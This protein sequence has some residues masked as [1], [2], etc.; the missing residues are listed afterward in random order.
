MRLTIVLITC[1][2]CHTALSQNNPGTFLSLY[3]EGSA[4]LKEKNLVK[5]EEVFL[6]AKDAGIREHGENSAD[7][8]NTYWS[9]TYVY[10]D[11]D[12]PDKAGETYYKVLKIH[13]SLN[14]VAKDKQD[15]IAFTEELGNFLAEKNKS[16]A[17]V[18]LFQ[19]AIR[20][21]EKIQFFEGTGYYWDL[22]NIM[23]YSYNQKKYDSL[24]Y[25]FG[26]I[27]PLL[28]SKS[29]EVRYAKHLSDW[30]S[31]LRAQKMYD[32]FD[33]VEKR[34]E[35]YLKARENEKKD[36]PYTSVL[37][38]YGKLLYGRG[39]NQ[40][41]LKSF[42]HARA[43]LEPYKEDNKAIYLNVFYFG[44]ELYNGLKKYD[45]LADQWF[46]DYEKINEL[47]AESSFDLYSEGLVQL[48][49]YNFYKGN[50]PKA[51]SL[52]RKTMTVYEKHGD[53]QGASYKMLNVFLAGILEKQGRSA[54]SQAIV[55]GISKEDENQVIA[56]LG[57]NDS[58]SEVDEL[59][60]YLKNAEYAKAIRLF[61]K[62]SDMIGSVY[63]KN[64]NFNALVM[65]TLGMSY[66]YRQTGNFTKAEELLITSTNLA[67]EKLGRTHPA[68]ILTTW[69]LGDFYQAIGS[70]P[71]AEKYF[72]D[73]LRL[74]DEVRTDANKEENDREFYNIYARL[75]AINV[76]FGEYDKAE[77]KY[78]KVLNYNW[79]TFG[80]DSEEY[81]ST[82]KSLADLYHSMK[83]FALAERYYT[84]VEPTIKKAGENSSSYIN[85]LGSL[86]LNYQVRGDYAKAEPMY[87]KVKE[88]YGRTLGNKSNQY[89]MVLSDLAVFYYHSNEWTKANAAFDE[90]TQLSLYKADNFFA[91]L[92]E[93]EKT[94]FYQ[95]IQS[96]FNKYNSF[97]IHYADKSPA[98]AG[99]LYNLQLLTKG[100]LF[101][102]TNRMKE[103]ILYG[104]DD[105]LKAQ[106]QRWI[107][108]KDMLSKVYQLSDAEKKASG[109]NEKEMEAS[110][111]ELEKS[112]T[113][114]SEQFASLL[115]VRPD[116]KQVQRKL[117][118]GEA[119][120]E[121]VR[122]KD[123]IPSYAFDY[124]GKG[125]Y[126]DS[127][128]N[129]FFRVGEVISDRTPAYRAGIR[130]GDM[131]LE[132]NGQTTKGKTMD[133]VGDLVGAPVAKMK[134]RKKGSTA[135]YAVELRPDSVFKRV[136]NNPI[137]YAA[138]ILTPETST[139]P[140]WV[141]L[142][143]GYQMETRYLNYYR[144]AIKSKLDDE[145]SYNIFWK[146]IREKIKNINTL[147]FSPDG[148]Y[149]SINLN[150]LYNPESKKYLLDEVNIRIVSS[151]ADLI[152]EMPAGD[153]TQVV[154]VGFPDYN[155][156]SSAIVNTKFSSLVDYKVLKGDTSQRFMSG[157]VV[158]ELPGTQ[159]EVNSIERVFQNGTSGVSKW[160][161][162]QATEENVKNVHSPKVLHI[163][164]H[165]FFM[166]DISGDKGVTG[167]SS[168]KLS[169]NPLLRSGLLLA[170][171]GNTLSSSSRDTKT[172]DGILTAYE[173]MNLDLQKTELVVLSA[174]ET[175]LGKV[176]TGE[177]VY[178]LQRAFR[179]A[180]ARNVLMSL[181]K[182]DDHATQELMTEFYTG[183]QRA[184]NK[185]ASFR[186]AQLRLRS[187]FAHPY[188]WGA[189][190]MVGN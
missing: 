114:R 46:A 4:L 156:K 16:L 55:K 132:I 95:D 34:C 125:F 124:V 57:L 141:L 172:E 129:D 101:R 11:T 183:W 50:L 76:S 83:L 176:T 161:A 122:V 128:K 67:K 189:F 90:L 120:I 33:R 18:R 60:R 181:W 186:E 27:A 77:E 127:I 14:T 21:R 32:K 54:E 117:R 7:V 146:P 134:L 153:A 40:R 51:E 166:N 36:L 80:A 123:A 105:S 78:F 43:L 130:E 110:V 97:G 23:N 139:N 13:R 160:L 113:R 169:E 75:A 175:G 84:E 74:L 112:L 69:N 106:Y 155:K 68:A 136:Y 184:G 2:I 89:A 108:K 180:G 109:I 163:A 178:G 102:S 140:Q 147:Y 56:G 187:K 145:L 37:F 126:Y 8:R 82:K 39:Q 38:T 22:T 115:N 65:M 167:V 143:N 6:K 118:P 73:A 53:A 131:V 151:T 52:I 157:S 59:G 29:S 144:N 185:N 149:N 79:S 190:V 91:S 179:A 177:G 148:L 24:D 138:L 92:S 121:I 107:V 137:I 25:F 135:T 170:G 111:N 100:M 30:S 98:E 62:S 87:L 103:T 154:L 17:A 96:K 58:M 173:A 71:R 85:L 150:T 86:A 28:D 31:F 64:N 20:E 164:T 72:N 66:C 19:I 93:Q 99:E 133:Q 26:K 12:Q 116:W 162:G 41:A 104:K 142:D 9:L 182:V 94:S 168:S 159:V 3:N 158:T 81:A 5:A 45:P 165:G 47:W 35:D 10:W 44:A 152:S 48:I 171:A 1:L 119:A 15:F 63:L 188:Y 70:L 88:F 42:A 49:N 174:C 61:E